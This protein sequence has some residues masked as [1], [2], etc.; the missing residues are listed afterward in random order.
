MRSIRQLLNRYVYSETYGALNIRHVLGFLRNG[1]IGPRR[2]LELEDN[3]GRDGD[4]RTANLR[5]V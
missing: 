5:F 1:G 4:R 2:V 3:F